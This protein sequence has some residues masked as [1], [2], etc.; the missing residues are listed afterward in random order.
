MYNHVVLPVIFAIESQFFTHVTHSDTGQCVQRVD[1]THRHD[2]RVQAVTGAIWRV[3]LGVDGSV[4]G[5]LPEV[6]H[7][8]LR[9]LDVRRVNDE[10]LTDTN[11]LFE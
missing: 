9:R 5:T 8:D 10:F 4:S 7:P 11:S 6:S 1:V 2:E 3:E